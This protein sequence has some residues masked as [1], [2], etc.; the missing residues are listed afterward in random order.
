MWGKLGPRPQRDHHYSPRLLERD[1]ELALIEAA[2][3]RARAGSGGLLVVEGP[4][5]IGKRGLVSEAAERAAGVMVLSARGAELEQDFAFGIVRQLLEPAVTG[6]SPLVQPQSL[7][8]VARRALIAL[9]LFVGAS[10]AAAADVGDTT[11]AGTSREYAAMIVHG[12]YWAIASLA[13]RGPLLVC[14]DD[15]HWSDSPSGRFVS[16]L[17][18]RLE[19]L[20]VAVVLALRPDERGRRASGIAEVA[21]SASGDLIALPPLREVACAELVRRDLGDAAEPLFWEACHAATA[22]NPFLL[23]ELIAQLRRSGVPPTSESA[24]RIGALRPESVTPRHTGDR[25]SSRR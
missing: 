9:E 21:S 25:R 1:H 6:T 23:T 2:V 5:G 10:G 11:L 8:G 17:S 13:E 12:L 20:P 15:A 14:I 18:Q 24:P 4:G 3:A 19:D 7:P 22:G 16:Y